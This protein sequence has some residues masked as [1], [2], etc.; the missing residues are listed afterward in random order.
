MIQGIPEHMKISREQAL[1]GNYDGALL[2]FDATVGLIH[3]YVFIAS[4]HLKQT[5]YMLLRI[6]I[7]C[8]C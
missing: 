1:L 5:R 3:Q 4:V 7:P 2:N 6:N 8:I